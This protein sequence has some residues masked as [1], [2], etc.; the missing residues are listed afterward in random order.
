[1]KKIFSRRRAIGMCV[2][3]LAGWW[4]ASLMTT[5]HAQRASNSLE[6]TWQVTVTPDDDTKKNGGRE[7]KLTLVFK[8]AEFSVTE[9]EKSGYKPAAYE[10]DERRFG[11]TKFDGTLTNAKEGEKKGDTAKWSGLATGQDIS[12]D[13]TWTKKNGDELK[14]TFKGTK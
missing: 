12:G 7:M 3:L 10:T 11:P 8:P 9:W 1:M 13:M 2:G 6:G 4:S 5:A 14:Y